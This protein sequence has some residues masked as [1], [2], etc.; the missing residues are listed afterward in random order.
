MGKTSL[1]VKYRPTK[2]E[3]VCEQEA[4]VI[5]LKNQILENKVV[6]GLLFCGGAGTGKTTSARIYANEINNGEG[7]PIELDAASHNSVD[8]IRDI[9]VNAQSK[10]IYSNYKVFI[11]DEV[12]ALSSSAWQAMLKILEEPPEKVVF[13]MCTTNPEKIP[14][15]ILSRVQRYDF[16]RISHESIV[17]RLVYIITKEQEE[18]YTDVISCDDDAIE[19]IAKQSEGGMR[20]AITLLE[21]CLSYSHCLSVENV[22]KALGITGYDDMFELLNFILNKDSKNIIELI[23]HVYMQGTDLKQY[24]K[25]FANFVLD[26]CKYQITKS[27]MYIQIPNIYKSKLDLISE[28]LGD[29]LDTLIKLNF[30]LKYDMTPKETI[31]SVLLLKV[32]S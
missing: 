32:M 16:R 13:I 1:A 27:F 6:H 7:S 14:A 26:V 17:K 19:Y 31:E 18:N 9:I 11:L 29:V 2:W 20:D 30:D 22:I 23:N 21:K 5:T 12:H 15:T 10:S 4:V 25:Q 3:D 28:E 24:M 8:D